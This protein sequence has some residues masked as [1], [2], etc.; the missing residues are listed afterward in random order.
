MPHP[1]RKTT[2]TGGSGVLT[3]RPTPQAELLH[4]SLYQ[5]RVRVLGCGAGGRGSRGDYPALPALG[6]ARDKEMR[7]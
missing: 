2:E 7:S 4:P 3:I 5:R 1:A 6:E